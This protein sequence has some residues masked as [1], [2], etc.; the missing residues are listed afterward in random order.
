MRPPPGF[1]ALNKTGRCANG[2]EADRGTITHAVAFGGYTALCGTRPGN[3]SDWS[4][5]PSDTVTCTRCANK[6]IAMNAPNK[7]LDPF[8]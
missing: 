1:H 4:S 7:K 2:A 6:I 3:R 8:A 5:W